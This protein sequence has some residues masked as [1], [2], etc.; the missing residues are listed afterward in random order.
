MPASS[1]RPH[2]GLLIVI[3]VINSL[4][5]A[6]YSARLTVLWPLSVAAYGAVVWLAAHRA[7][8]WLAS[9][10]ARGRAGFAVLAALLL[11]G[12]ALLLWRIDPMT[13]NVDRFSAVTAFCDHLLRGE[14]PY[15][16]RTHLGNQVSGFPGLFLLMLP[17]HLLGHAGWFNLAVFVL[18]VRE[19]YRLPG[20]FAVRMTVLLLAGTA[21]A[22]VW[23][24]AAR[25]ELFA[26]LVL[27][28]IFCR[29]LWENRGGSSTGKGILAGAL[30]ALLLC[31]RGI[32]LLPLTVSGIAFLRQ[33][34][35]RDWILPGIAL[36]VTLVLL[37]LPFQLWDPAQFA[38]NDPF[39]KQGR[40][41]P[42]PLALLAWMGAVVIG[43]RTQTR[44]AAM[45]WTGVLLFATVLLVFAI[46][47]TGMGLRKAI[48]GSGFDITYFIF[49]MPFMLV[50]LYRDRGGVG[51]SQV[52]PARERLQRESRG[53]GGRLAT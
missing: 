23:E 10:E 31:T 6:K 42:L 36:A 43:Y 33:K 8:L 49:G 39:A 20:S 26:N 52:G 25:S 15:A 27:A 5:V 34:P 18:F 48:F 30:A 21:P 22:V 4:L 32:V 11:A 47:A 17:L 14:F 28:L 35:V 51:A 1:I 2:R 37:L 50:A 7:P 46:E 13:L 45:V 16:A 9:L 12:Y 44:H 41:I 3:I 38:A 19:L 24:T 40:Y 53:A 29:W